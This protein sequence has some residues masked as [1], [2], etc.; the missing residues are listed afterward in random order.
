MDFSDFQTTRHELARP[1]LVVT[2]SKGTLACGYLNVATFDALEE[3]GAIVRGVSNF[4][5][6]LEAEVVEVSKAAQARGVA[7]GMKGR[8]ALALFR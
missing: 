6:M 8:D 7:V 4:D 3:S 1:L 5:D 2:G